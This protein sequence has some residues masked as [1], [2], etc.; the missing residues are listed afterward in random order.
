MTAKNLPK[1]WKK[2][3]K[4]GKKRGKSGK[5]GKRA[6]KRRKGKNW[7]D[8]FTLPLLTE[9]AGYPLVNGESYIPYFEYVL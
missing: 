4:I 3:E 1:I 2:R 8:S 7:E 9:R 5:E 6:K